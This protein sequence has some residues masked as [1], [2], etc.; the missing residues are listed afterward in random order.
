MSEPRPRSTEPD[1][2]LHVVSTYAGYHFFCRMCGS[3]SLTRESLVMTDKHAETHAIRCVSIVEDIYGDTRGVILIGEDGRQK[4]WPC[5][6]KRLF[7][8]GGSS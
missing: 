6:Q 3:R 5:G 7:G 2:E 8:D 4:G 1:N